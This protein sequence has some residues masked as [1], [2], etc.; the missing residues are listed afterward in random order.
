[1]VPRGQRRVKLSGEGCR[2]CGCRG[3]TKEDREY[4]N[5]SKK[6]GDVSNRDNKNRSFDNKNF[7]NTN[8]RNNYNNRNTNNK[9]YNNNRNH[10]ATNDN[11][12]NQGNHR[13]G[14]YQPFNNNNNNYHG[15]NAGG[16]GNANKGHKKSLSYSSDSSYSDSH[17][18]DESV[19]DNFNNLYK[20]SFGSFLYSQ[21]NFYPPLLGFGIPQRSNSYIKG[22]P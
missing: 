20:S 3:C 13:G 18:S 9:N 17:S 4:F 8:N 19:D 2:T 6:E 12:N 21:L 22:G 14:G 5:H 1:M 11:N 10:V 7:N 16:G 15:G